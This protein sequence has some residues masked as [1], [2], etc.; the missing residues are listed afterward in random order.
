LTA[1]GTI[2]PTARPSHSSTPVA[3][4]SPSPL[5]S[6]SLM[7]FVP[8][9]PVV[10]DKATPLPVAFA[11]S[12]QIPVGAALELVALRGSTDIVVRDITNVSK[13]VTRCGFKTCAQFCESY[14]PQSMRFVTRTAISYIVRSSEGVGGMY[15][16]DLATSKTVLIRK[17]GSSENYFWLYAWSPDGNSFTY[18]TSTEWRIQTAS[19]DVA[20]SPLGKGLQFNFRG[21]VVSD[22]VGFSA[23]GLYVS[24]NQANTSGALFQVVRLADLKVVYS[25]RNGSMA[26][27]AGTGAQLFF[28]VGPDLDVWDPI[29][30]ARLVVRGLAWT[31]PVPSADGKRIVYEVA[32]AAGYHFPRL[33]RLTDQPLKSI[34]LSNLHRANTTLLTPTLVWYAAEAPCNDTPCRCDDAVCEP[35]LT[36]RTYVHDLVTGVISSSIVTG[37]ADSWPHVAGQS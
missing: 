10:P 4:S 30:G 5:S 22:S 23:D 33:V 25:S 12:T 9:S 15:L 26:T 3:A 37:V 1:C 7:P 16:A 2:S 28:R 29:N 34:T 17:W 8:P 24:A 13:P 20:L 14:G 18:F 21:D 32:S 31:N 11:C 35:W 19:G 6:P 36:G 27:W